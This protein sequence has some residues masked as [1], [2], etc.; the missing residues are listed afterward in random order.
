MAADTAK[1]QNVAAFVVL[2][3][4]TNGRDLPDPSIFDCSAKDNHWDWR[5]EG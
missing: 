2:H 3:D 4:T 1:E 5:A